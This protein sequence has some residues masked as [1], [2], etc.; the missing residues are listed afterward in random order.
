[1]SVS[2]VSEVSADRRIFGFLDSFGVVLDGLNELFVLEGPVSQ[3]FLY[4]ARLF[5][6]LFSFFAHYVIK[7]I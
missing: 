3:V 7:L 5:C 6:G 2:P 4:L 1:M